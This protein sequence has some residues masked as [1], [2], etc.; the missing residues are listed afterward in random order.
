MPKNLIEKIYKREETPREL[1]ALGFYADDDNSASRGPSYYNWDEAGHGDYLL[2]RILSCVE[3]TSER[4]YKSLY[5]VCQ[6]Y[7]NRLQPG[8]QVKIKAYA[9]I[10][11]FLTGKKKDGSQASRRIWTDKSHPGGTAP[12]YLVTFS[13]WEGIPGHEDKSAPK[14]WFVEQKTGGAADPNLP[15]NTPPA[16][17]APPAEDNDDL[18]F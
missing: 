10:Q 17:P 13:G 9:N 6:T 1:V 4:G 11:P 8:D 16:P 15:K 12:I 14:L 5:M 7:N 3:E 18:P 2:I